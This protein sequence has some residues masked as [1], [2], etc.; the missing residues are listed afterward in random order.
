MTVRRFLPKSLTGQI[1]LLIVLSLALA[2]ALSIVVMYF[3]LTIDAPKGPPTAA[4]RAATIVQLADAAGSETKTADLLELARKIGVAVTP[5]PRGQFLSVGAN[6]AGLAFR[7]KQFLEHFETMAGL[8][9][10]Q[11]R[12]IIGPDNSVMTL[13]ADGEVLAF[14][15]PEGGGLGV[16]RMIVAPV[17]YIS[18]TIAMVLI[19][20]S[21][22]AARFVTSPLSSFAA[23]AHAVGRRADGDTAIAES[24]PR[25][26]A[27]V[28]RAM[29]EMRARI[30][31]LLD[32]RVGMLTAIS[33]DLRTPLTRIRLRAERFYE[34]PVFTGAAEGML[35]DIS[36]MEQMLTETL[37]YM[38][39]YVHTEPS[40]PVDLPSVLETICIE[41]AD[42]GRA[43]TYEGPGKLVYR[44]QPSA[45][46]RAVGNLVDNGLEHGT[47]VV[48]KL[49]TLENRAVQIDVEDDGP[50]I[51]YPLRRR[52]FEPFFKVDM[53]R[54]AGGK[55]GFGLGLSIARNIV[56]A[57]RGQIELLDRVPRGLR[58]R[59]IL[60]SDRSE[61][62]ATKQRLFDHNVS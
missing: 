41:L 22:Y 3:F 39:D 14:P 61:S 60:P 29:N 30:R 58:V 11:D 37:A 62:P 28:A 2:N 38:R 12:V 44:C 46:T 27:Q 55:E 16:P 32:E 45:L 24:G 35:A 50:G 6:G 54:T 31:A 47:R 20:L 13:L 51:P 4:I 56:E 8:D 33:H 42:L 7:Q 52:V 48:V 34:H 18:T 1:T 49:A 59:I 53:A 43:V 25:E 19:G 9:P 15:L 57:H 17:V 26:I 10:A 21:L 40:L 36:R 23:A 5:V